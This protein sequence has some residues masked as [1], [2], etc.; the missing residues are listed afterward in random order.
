MLVG[1]FAAPQ[2]DRA[3]AGAAGHVDA[4][5][6]VGG[7]GPRRRQGR[8]IAEIGGVAMGVRRRGWVCRLTALEHAADPHQP[9]MPGA[10]GQQAG[11]G[12]GHLAPG[13]VHPSAVE[14]AG[15][16]DQ[17]GDLGGCSRARVQQHRAIAPGHAPGDDHPRHVDQPADRVA[18]GGGLQDHPPAF[19]LDAAAVVDQHVARRVRRVGGQGQLQEAVARQVQGRRQAR[20]QRHPA[21]RRADQPGVGH[22]SADQGD[23]GARPTEDAAL[24]E[25]GPAVAF[26]PVAAGHEVGVLDVQGRADEAAPGVDGPGRGHHQAVAVDHEH[27]AV[28]AQGP[29]DARRVGTRHPVEDGRSGARL[30][31]LDAGAGADAEA[32]PFD[33]G[34]GRRLPDGQPGGSRLDRR[35]ARLDRAAGRK[36]LGQ[37]GGGDEQAQPEGAGA[38]PLPARTR[39]GGAPHQNAIPKEAYNRSRGGTPRSWSV[40]PYSSVKV[41]LPPHGKFFPAK[42]RPRP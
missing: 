20:G 24:V 11:A 31:E 34:L 25:D 32:V 33:H 28:A 2:D 29:G 8:Q 5:G 37:G 15:D 21:Q 35:A 19:R 12:Q 41:G 10:R 22:L 27:L 38:Q 42:R 40:W 7:G 36:L 30:L 13:H 17:A 23:G 6:R 14:I 9:A 4:R 3:A 18:R 39:C 1:V 16:V 26:E